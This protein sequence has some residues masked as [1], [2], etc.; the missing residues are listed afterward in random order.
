MTMNENTEFA[1]VEAGS[2]GGFGT[3][4]E[5][6]PMEYSAAIGGPDGDVWKEEIKKT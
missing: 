4:H 1:N 5:L 6:R 2:R 3:T